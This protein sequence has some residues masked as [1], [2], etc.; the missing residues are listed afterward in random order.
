MHVHIPHILK[1]K[2]RHCWFI[3][4]DNSEPSKSNSGFFYYRAIKALIRAGISPFIFYHYHCSVRSWW[5][6]RKLG[7]ENGGQ[8][9]L[10]KKKKGK[11][12]RSRMKSLLI[13]VWLNQKCLK[14]INFNRQIS[15]I[16]H[17]SNFFKKRFFL[18]PLPGI[19]FI[20]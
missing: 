1:W 11:R 4:P 9:W 7:R 18:F 6:R 15:R 5:P 17:N 16:N 19:Y 10:F 13:Q 14:H 12:R 3:P 20:I 2:C 8:K